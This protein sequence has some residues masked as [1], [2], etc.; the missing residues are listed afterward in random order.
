MPLKKSPVDS[1]P[2]P[3]V[4]VVFYGYPPLDVDERPNVALMVR[5][6]TLPGR[7]YLWSL[8]DIFSVRLTSH[9]DP[10]KRDVLPL[11]RS[12]VLQPT[13][14]DGG[15]VD[16][17][18]HTWEKS[19][20]TDCTKNARELEKTL[21]ADITAEEARRVQIQSS[22]VSTGLD[23]RVGDTYIG[24]RNAHLCFA[25]QLSRFT[26]KEESVDEHT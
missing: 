24:K 21:R 6:C 15:V 10:L 16:I 7:G 2:K 18:G 26:E 4:A 17:Y 20:C 19:T 5:R 1:G 25:L 23:I 3:A 14:T 8:A 13:I 9:A 22:R 12:N 11:L